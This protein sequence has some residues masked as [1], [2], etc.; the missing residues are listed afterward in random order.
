MQNWNRPSGPFKRLLQRWNWRDTLGFLFAF[1]PAILLVI[2]INQHSVNVPV[3][4]DWEMVPL[5]E[6]AEQGELTFKDLYAPHISHRMVF[7]R[8]IIL[9]LIKVSGGDLRWLIGVT[10]ALGLTA[11][12][13]IWQLARQ[14]LFKNRHTTWGLL[15]LVNLIIF[16]PLQWQ[17]WLWAIQVAFMLPM[18]CIIWSLVICGKT[19]WRWWAR[20]LA[21][22]AL[23]V[24]STHSFGHGVF[25]WPAVFG[26]V[27]LAPRFS[28]V[29]WHRWAFLGLWV[30]V[31]AAVITCYFG[32]DFKN[33]S[34]ASHAY[35]QQ[36][37]DAPPMV[38]SLEAAKEDPQRV[39]RFFRTIVGNPFARV[40]GIDP[41]TLAPKI[42]VILLSLF[43][44]CVIWILARCRKPGFWEHSLPWLALSGTVLCAQAA[45]TI[46]R[47]G[48]GGLNRATITRYISISLYLVIAILFL[49]ALIWQ[50]SEANWWK[51]RRHTLATIIIAAFAGMQ[52]W[53]WVYGRQMMQLWEWARYEE[54]ASLIFT[55]HW[56]AQ[57][58]HRTDATVAFP[59]R[60]ANTLNRL[61]YLKPELVKTLE[62]AQFKPKGKTLTTSRAKVEVFEA[63]GDGKFKISGFTRLG[64]P[65]YRPVDGILLT[66][67]TKK[68]KPM[69]FTL[70][71]S[72][73]RPA[74]PQ[75]HFD[76]E[77]TG[78]S[79]LDPK[80]FFRWTTIFNR[81]QIPSPATDTAGSNGPTDASSTAPI[82]TVR[83]W[84]LDIPKRRAYAIKGSWD[85]LPNGSIKSHP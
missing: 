78:R 77:F 49:I 53:P 26:L 6:K 27:L 48:L 5:I 14:T 24:I 38:K 37:G 39:W 12:L 10:F 81:K 34:D 8:L 73:D 25:V 62:L 60:Y 18:T 3:W 64:K 41:L 43:G 29:G 4:D 79:S 31:A 67:E 1:S 17:N 50:S 2:L 76:L 22:I 74:P 59:R 61:G 63:L 85:L 21:C 19:H 57:N 55:N 84:A 7:P 47:V 58:P 45:I 9:G 36:P 80:D 82:I 28:T 65:V 83:A 68:Q 51:S 72:G 15:F 56:N 69:I 11:A 52:L 16:S 32:L 33:T 44:L 20:A 75:Y 46:S 35:F 23:A 42:G 70:V 40:Y 13:G 30:A 71:E 54:Q 66:W